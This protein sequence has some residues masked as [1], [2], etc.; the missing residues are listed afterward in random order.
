[1]QA[2]GRQ[3]MALDQLEERHDGEGSVADLVSQRRQWQIDA[4]GLK[5]HTLAVERDMHTEL[6]EQDRR[7][8]LRT[9]MKPRGVAW[10]GAAAG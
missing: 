8:Q 10:N 1:M 2:L 5:A 9:P 4:L 6:V 7:Q 3:H